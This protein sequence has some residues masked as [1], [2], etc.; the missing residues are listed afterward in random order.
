MSPLP[1]PPAV[2]VAGGG[3]G[4]AA[5]G[6]PFPAGYELPGPHQPPHLCRAAQPEGRGSA[7][8]GGSSGPPAGAT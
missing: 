3:G 2:C 1:A 6:G 4:G 7:D 5:G 8:P